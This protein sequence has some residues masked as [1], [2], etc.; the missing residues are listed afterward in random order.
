[1][2]VYIFPFKL[3]VITA[4]V[5]LINAQFALTVTPS[6]TLYI[7]IYSEHVKLMIH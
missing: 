1:M 4:Y 5:Q 2:N 7:R 6:C 3:C